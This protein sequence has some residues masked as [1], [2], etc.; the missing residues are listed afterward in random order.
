M[1]RRFSSR[2]PAMLAPPV[3]GRRLQAEQHPMVSRFMYP[4]ATA[5]RPGSY[6]G[7]QSPRDLHM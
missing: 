7:K 1:K 4:P 2:T 6:P 3:T 5:V